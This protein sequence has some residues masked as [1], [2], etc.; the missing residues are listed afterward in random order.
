MV[1]IVGWVERTDL[2]GWSIK[3]QAKPNNRQRSR[4]DVR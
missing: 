4:A 3:T 1:G 2:D